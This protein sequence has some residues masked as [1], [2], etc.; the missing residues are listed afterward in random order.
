M[1]A[2]ALGAVF[3]FVAAA[4]WTFPLPPPLETGHL[5]GPGL[6]AGVPPVPLEGQL[7]AL[8]WSA[9]GKFA[10]LETRPG[11]A[12]RLRVADL[13]EDRI[14]DE[15]VWSDAVGDPEPWWPTHE[16]EAD[17][18]FRRWSLEPNTW[19]LGQFPLILDNEYYTLALRK[20]PLAGQ[21]GVWGRWEALVASTGRGQKSVAAF[22]GAWRWVSVL[23][24]VP[25]PFENRVALILV[26]QPVGWDQGR[27]SL[28]F[29][30]VG[31]SLKAGFRQP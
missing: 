14:V 4:G 25:S 16:A 19:Q 23:G 18:L 5:L 7:Y 9:D 10:T 21:P 6:P 15:R 13:V 2:L 20:E 31:V 8:G 17:A 27:Q 30:V 1:K 3:G 12:A 24:F 28:S 29:G 26:F 22:D 11:A